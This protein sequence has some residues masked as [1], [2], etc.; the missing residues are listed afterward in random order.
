MRTRTGRFLERWGR[1]LRPHRPR[2]TTRV[3]GWALEQPVEGARH[4][5]RGVLRQPVDAVGVIGTEFVP[6]E[7]RGEFVVIV[8]A[9]AGHVVR[10]DASRTSARSSKVV[11]EHA[12]SAAGLLH[13]RRRR[14]IRCKATL[15]VKADA[16]STSA[17]A[18]SSDSRPTCASA[19][20]ADAAARR[21]RSPIRSSCR[22]RR[23]RRRSASIVRGDDM[24]ELQRLSDEVVAEGHGRCPAPSTSTARSRAASRR[25]SARVN[26]ELAADLGFDVGS[27]A[28]QLRGMVEGIVPTQAARRR[29]GIRHPR[30]AGAGVPQRLPGDRARRRSTRRRG[31]VGPHR[32]TSSRWSRASARPA[33]TASSAGGRRRSASSSS[34]RAARRR[35]RRRRQGDGDGARCRRTSSGASPATSR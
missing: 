23:R 4:R 11:Q 34:D 19:L 13:R 17:S 28:M 7:D 24:A 16:R 22:A 25:W 8:E 14:Q 5:R 10:A 21:R 15:R 29:Q 6:A 30:A 2:S 33:S 27:V 18:A 9:A 31:A 35:H 12:G 20:A 1:V 26:R 3:L 32:A